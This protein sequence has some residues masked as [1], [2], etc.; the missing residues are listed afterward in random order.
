MNKLS[1]DFSAYCIKTLNIGKYSDVLDIGGGH[2]ADPNTADRYQGS[3]S[4]HFRHLFRRTVAI[5]IADD[6]L[7][8]DLIIDAADLLQHF[9]KKTF[10][11]VVCQSTLEN[12]K[13]ELALKM[14]DIISTLLKDN[15]WIILSGETPQY[16][17]K[18][19]YPETERRYRH[20][21]YTQQEIKRLFSNFKLVFPP[22]Y[23]RYNGLWQCYGYKGPC[24][25]KPI[26]KK[27]T[28]NKIWTFQKLR[29][30]G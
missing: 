27:Y 6:G 10:D 11:F 21:Q 1:Y 8:V 25:T 26:H 12:F 20:H 17:I 19:D 23:N 2:P 7:N 29:P 30:A 18:Y 4:Y 22:K 9:S 14:P 28:S 24:L 3:F 13:M 15:G 16:I 5:D